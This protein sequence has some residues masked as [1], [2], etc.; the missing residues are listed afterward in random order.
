MEGKER[1]VAVVPVTA[2]RGGSVDVLDAATN[3]DGTV[4][5]VLNRS[6]RL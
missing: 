4:I 3:V 1:T 5:E 2:V 6:D